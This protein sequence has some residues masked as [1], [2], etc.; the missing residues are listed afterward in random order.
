MPLSGPPGSPSQTMSP[1]F[2]AYL[3]ETRSSLT[4]TPAGLRVSCRTAPSASSHSRA[5]MGLTPGTSRYSRQSGSD[6]IRTSSTASSMTSCVPLRA[7]PSTVRVAYGKGSGIVLPRK[8]A[9]RRPDPG[10]IVRDPVRNASRGGCAILAGRRPQGNVGP[11]R[12]SAILRAVLTNTRSEY[13]T[14]AEEKSPGRKVFSYGEAV[15]MLPE[16]RRLTEQAH[17]QVTALTTQ[18]DEGGVARQEIEEAVGEVSRDWAQAMVG[19]GLEVKGLWL[20]DWDNGSGYY[21][22]K[23][24]EDGLHYFHSYE[25]GFRGRMRIQ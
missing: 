19:M 18:A 2:S 11:R 14:M 23:H 20:V 9:V 4:H 22:W 13:P 21:C 8:P 16:V 10:M 1:S 3:S 24:P 7:P 5:W 12:P 25:E 15:A 17:Q 6:P